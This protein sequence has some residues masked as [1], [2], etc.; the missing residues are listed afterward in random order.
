MVKILGAIQQNGKVILGDDTTH[1]NKGIGSISVMMQGKETARIND[2][3]YVL[4][5][6]RSLFSVAK[7]GTQG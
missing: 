1:S 4:K 6:K 3:L 2:V 5:W 7:M